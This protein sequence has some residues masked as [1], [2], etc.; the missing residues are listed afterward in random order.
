MKKIILLSL[1]LVLFASCAKKTEKDRVEDAF[2]HYIKT[3]FNDTREFKKIT[4]IEPFDTITANDAIELFYEPYINR[5]NLRKEELNKLNAFEEK[6]KKDTTTMIKYKVNTMLQS[7]DKKYPVTFFVIKT[8]D[9]YKVQN[10]DLKIEELTGLWGESVM[11][12]RD[13]I[14]RQMSEL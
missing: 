14:Y 7:F 3:E 2:M 12:A 6:L 8:G 10:H 11:F 5:A 9:S 4:S 13:I 1:A